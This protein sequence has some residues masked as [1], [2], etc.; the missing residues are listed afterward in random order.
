MSEDANV[1]HTINA[2]IFSNT[3]TV[4][5]IN[6]F[7]GIR[8][9]AGAQSTPADA[10]ILRLDLNNNNASCATGND[11]TVRQ[12]FA[13][14]VQLLNYA[15]GSTDAAAVQTYLDV[16]KVNNPTGAGIDWFITTQ[17]PGG[18]F[19]NT[20]SVPQPTLPTP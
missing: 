2:T 1:A 3:A 19:V 18:G 9:V 13:T 7:D 17:A 10:G 4:S 14:T 6:S 8:V 20:A 11:F 5:D 16:T 15:G 12:R